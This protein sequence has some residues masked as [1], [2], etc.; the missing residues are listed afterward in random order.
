MPAA[1]IIVQ[2]GIGHILMGKR[3]DTKKWTLVAG[4]LN[5]GE[6][7]VDG[8]KRELKEEA[9]VTCDVL[10]EIPEVDPTG[11]LTFFSCILPNST[12]FTSKNDPDQEVAK[13]QWV[14]VRGG[15]P[16]NIYENLAGP[17][18]DANIIRKLYSSMDL[19]KSELEWLPGGFLDLSQKLEIE[20]TLNL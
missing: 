11:N 1:V 3:K 8:A 20:Y 14:D 2:D 5:P 17:E 13:W 16:K 19:Q 4:G 18:G 12:K 9:G 15:I 10:T 6:A 7:P